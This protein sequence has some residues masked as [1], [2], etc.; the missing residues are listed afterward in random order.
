MA[1]SSDAI[2]GV[3]VTQI[4]VPPG[5][6][7]AVFIDLQQR[8]TS[9]LVKYFSGGTLEIQSANLLTGSTLPGSSLAPLQ[10]TGYILGTSEALNIDGPTRFYLMASGSTAIACLMR[11]LTAPGYNGVQGE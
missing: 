4:I 6:S 1:S 9:T 2:F 3:G 11:G 10:G 7:F 5:G 8:Q